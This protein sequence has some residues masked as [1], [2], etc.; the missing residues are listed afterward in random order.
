MGGDAEGKVRKEKPERDRE[1]K[2]GMNITEAVNSPQT[3]TDT[4]TE[5]VT[6]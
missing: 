5:T 2:A 4:H 6:N 1:R 3:S